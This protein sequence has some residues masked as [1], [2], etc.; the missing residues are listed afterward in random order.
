[1]LTLEGELDLADTDQ[2]TEQVRT[3]FDMVELAAVAP[4]IVIAD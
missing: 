3:V 4:H 1:M 2:P